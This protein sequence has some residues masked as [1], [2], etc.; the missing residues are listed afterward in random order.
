[1]APAL[2]ERKVQ[3]V[4]VSDAP[5]MIG[6]HPHTF[7]RILK[8]YQIKLVQGKLDQRQWFVDINKVKDAL[9]L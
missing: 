4:R 1:M 9:D 6:V 2:K 7:R 3:L 5:A 8:R